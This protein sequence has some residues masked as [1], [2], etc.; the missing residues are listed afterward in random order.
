M[1]RARVIVAD[2]HP[3]VLRAVA[4]MIRG[5]PDLDLVAACSDGRA[6]LDAIREHRPDLAV[7]DLRM[8]LMN[9]VEV[10]KAVGAEALPT[11]VVLLTA[12]ITD[13]LVHDG[14]A[15]GCAGIV[16]KS[17][18]PDSLLASIHE[19]IAGGRAAPAEFLQEALARETARRARADRLL[20]SLTAREREVAALATQGLSNKE[21]AR[22][23]GIS[24]GTVK[25]HLNSVFGKL[26][27]NSRAGLTE[28]VKEFIDRLGRGATNG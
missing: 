11:R 8:P 12:E 15:L 21:I 13:D 1:T 14:V 7:I 22:K 5:E 10:L 18:E 3:M 25:L 16:L 17:A 19:V 23:L 28:V 4:Q 6:A 24:E 20:E 26:G 27:V 9:G 2:D